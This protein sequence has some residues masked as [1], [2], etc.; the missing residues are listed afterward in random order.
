M[1]DKVRRFVPNEILKMF[2]KIAIFIAIPN[3]IIWFDML[4]LNISKK[5]YCM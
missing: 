3:Q 2:E 4:N 5:I 1:L